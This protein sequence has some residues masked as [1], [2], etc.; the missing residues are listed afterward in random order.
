MA[1][2]WD[3]TTPYANMAVGT[4]VRALLTHAI[5][6][7][8]SGS[9]L[10]GSFERNY[11]RYLPYAACQGVLRAARRFNRDSKMLGHKHE[12]LRSS[13]LDVLQ[14]LL[15]YQRKYRGRLEPTTVCE[16]DARTRY[17]R[18]TVHRALDLLRRYSFLAWER[19]F[20]HVQKPGEQAPRKQQVSS[21]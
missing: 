18:A 19:R 20:E 5:D 21:T 9:L 11:W 3:E 12:A 1:H 7:V 4:A 2:A 17:H 16:I 8:W 15:S 14:F 13:V 6:K 10:L